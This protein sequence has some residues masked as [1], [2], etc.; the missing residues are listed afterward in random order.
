MFCIR[1]KASFRIVTVAIL[2]LFVAY[3]SIISVPVEA[4]GG[5]GGGRAGG[6][7]GGL[8]R[9]SGGGFQRPSGGFQQP[10]GG[11]QRPSGGFQQPSGGFQRPSG[12][13]P[14]QRPSNWPSNRPYPGGYTPRTNIGNNNINNGTINV[15]GS[16]WGWGGDGAWG[17]AA[18]GAAVGAAAASSASSEPGTVIYSLPPSC[19]PVVVDGVTYQNC[20]GT[21]Y[22]PAYQG[23]S[24]VYQT[25][26][27][28]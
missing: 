18:V 3:F 28:P 9:P 14:A 24:V 12:A 26:P 2:A 11:V 21:Y 23:S 7:G 13:G 4:R 6:G 27:A 5:R 22:Q 19:T 8:S 1:F 16:D 10:S 20:G 17:A 25:V 15:N